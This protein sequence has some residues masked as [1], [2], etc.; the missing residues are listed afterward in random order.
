MGPRFPHPELMQ[1]QGRSRALH[2]QSGQFAMTCTL[3]DSFLNERHMVLPCFS[4]AVSI[5]GILDMARHIRC[6]SLTQ[7]QITRKIDLE[8]SFC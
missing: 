7:V 4:V 6:Q 8:E 3:I 5:A 1:T 2:G